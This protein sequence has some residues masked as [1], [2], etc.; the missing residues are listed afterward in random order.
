[1]ESHN[2][3]ELLST[4][5]PLNHE[6]KPGKEKRSCLQQWFKHPME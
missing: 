1:M 5:V 6:Q 4:N 2:A 3:E